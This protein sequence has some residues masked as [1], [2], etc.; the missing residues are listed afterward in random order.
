MDKGKQHFCHVWTKRLSTCQAYLQDM[1]S[2][3]DMQILQ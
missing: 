2:K 3:R 1:R